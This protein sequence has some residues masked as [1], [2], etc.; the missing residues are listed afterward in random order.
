ME[1]PIRGI[2][3]RKRGAKFCAAQGGC[4][5]C[6][7][8]ARDRRARE[9][10]ALQVNPAGDMC[11]VIGGGCVGGGTFAALSRMISMSGFSAP[12]CLK[13]ARCCFS[14]IRTGLINGAERIDAQVAAAKPGLPL[15]SPVTTP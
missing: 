4:R 14:T 10:S 8:W 2:V 15:V 12:V 3:P 9:E 5:W 1:W 13:K 7:L 6:G 11:W